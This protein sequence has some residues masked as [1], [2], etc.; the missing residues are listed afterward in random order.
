MSGAESVGETGGNRN[1]STAFTPKI[2]PKYRRRAAQLL[3]GVPAP[4]EEP[5]F[6]GLDGESLEAEVS[7]VPI[8]YDREPASVQVFLREI[9]ER[10]SNRGENARLETVAPARRR[11]RA[12]GRL[13]G[14]VVH[15]FSNYLDGYRR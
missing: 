13:A 14:G 7:A 11:W 2:T 8:R 4:L 6:C 1:V 10:S 5:T 3:T 15:H 9:T 12:V